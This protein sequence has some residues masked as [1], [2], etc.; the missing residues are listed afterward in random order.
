MRL[1]ALLTHGLDAVLDPG[2]VAL[3]AFAFTLQILGDLLLQ[4][5]GFEGIVALLLGARQTQ[6]ESRNIV[7][8]LVDERGETTVFAFVVFNAQG[9]VGRFPG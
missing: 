8:L 5:E 1:V 6:R 9:Q 2:Q 3:V 7:F 4:D